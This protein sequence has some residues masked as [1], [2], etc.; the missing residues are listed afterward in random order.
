M[1]GRQLVWDQQRST[2]LDVFTQ[3]NFDRNKST[4]VKYLAWVWTCFLC[5]SDVHPIKG[6]K[7]TWGGGLESKR[8]HPKQWCNARKTRGAD[9]SER[10]G[11]SVRRERKTNPNQETKLSAPVQ[12]IGEEC[13]TYRRRVYLLLLRRENTVNK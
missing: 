8:H 13:G 10:E 7:A 4:Y 1:N 2:S 6:A 3:L 11:K 12:K 5:Y 9:G